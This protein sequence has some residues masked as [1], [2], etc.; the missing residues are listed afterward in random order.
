MIG[1]DVFS[2]VFQV[3]FSTS[4]KLS[5]YIS[6]LVNHCLSDSPLPLITI[7]VYLRIGDH[8]GALHL[9]L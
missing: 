8:L 5:E 6:C 1:S 7:L 4:E 9:V 3:V 2:F